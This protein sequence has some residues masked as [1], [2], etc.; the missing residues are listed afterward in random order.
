MDP[1]QTPQTLIHPPLLKD[2]Q[3]YFFS[4]FL[5]GAH[6]FYLHLFTLVSFFLATWIH[7]V[8]CVCV[9]DGILKW[10]FVD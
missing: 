1:W 2:S 8:V 4:L 6:P 3:C 10:G 5:L 7:Y 9:C